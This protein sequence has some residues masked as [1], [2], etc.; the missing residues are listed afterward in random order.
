MNPSHFALDAGCALQVSAQHW[1]TA[2]SGQAEL[3]LSAVAS[4]RGAVLRLDI[5]YHGGSGF[6][7]ARKPLRARLPASWTV[8]FRLRG[9]TAAQDLEV[10]L[11]D[12][13]GRNVWRHVIRPLAASARWRR[14]EIPS[15]RIEFA[16]GPS[17]DGA[18]VELG[19]IEFAL[20]ATGGD[21][22]R[23]WLEIGD[24]RL[25]A[26]DTGGPVLA[27]ASS[28]RPGRE[29]AQA[30]TH[31]GWKPQVHD[32]SPWL[33]LD[34]QR[35][36]DF[37]GVVIE[38]EEA[39]PSTGFRIRTS[40]TGRRW[41]TRYATDRAGG[42]RSYVALPDA[43][44]RY[45]RLE[46][47][48]A[49]VGARVRLQNFTF[50]R[51]PEAY[52]QHVAAAEPRGALP[53]WLLREQCLWTPVGTPHSGAQV[54][55]D[56]DGRFEFAPG[57]ALIEPLLSVNGRLHTWADV[58]AHP[59]LQDG[60]MPQPS[61]RWETSAWTL[62]IAAE[63]TASGTLRLRYRLTNRGNRRL[64]A[65]LFLLIRPFQITP[66]WQQH[67]ELGGLRPIHRLAWDGDTLHIDG[68]GVVRP[69]SRTARA[70]AWRA[71]DGTP[72]SAVQLDSRLRGNDEAWQADDP[73]G[74][75]TGALAFEMK[76]DAGAHDE[77]LLSAASA[78]EQLADA[79]EPAFD[80][81]CVV[82]TSMLAAGG[83]AMDAMRAAWTATAHIL[84][85]RDGAALQPGPRRYR[86]SWIRDGAV[87]AA[88]LLRMKQTDAV[89][90][91]I[92]WYAPHV[93]ADGFV[94][95]CVDSRGA[96]PLVEHDSHGQWLALIADHQ[97]FAPD[98]ALLDRLW[99]S[100]E[101]TVNRIGGLLDDS[102]LLPVSVSHEGY[103]AQP[104]HA[105]WD[106]AWAVRGLR[107]MAA[108][109]RLHHRSELAQRCDDLQRRIADAL[110]ASIAAT[111]ARQSLD[112]IP[113]SV[114]WAD[115]DPTATAQ[116]ITLL[117]LP[118]QLDRTAVERTYTRYLDDWRSKR[119]NETDWV[120][121]SP[122]EIRIVG[123]LLRLGWRDAALDLLRFLLADR[124]PPAWNQWPEIAW[125]DPRTPGHL[126]DLPHTW[127]A[128]EYVLALRSLFAYESGTQDALIL[129][130]GLDAD[131]LAGE[132]VRVHDLPTTRGTLHYT[133]RRLDSATTRFELQPGVAGRIVLRPPLTG[134]IV[135]VE[136]DDETTV[137][138]DGTSVTIDRVTTPL[139]LHIR[140]SR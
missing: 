115:F 15:R 36:R 48:D 120:N 14:Y 69:L 23:G 134:T 98:P 12:A 7:V 44:F 121:Y 61:V 77:V 138:H 104:V 37:G 68:R 42:P 34:T 119:R 131:W 110:F 57:S 41:T 90:A 6:V 16:W 135:T 71:A 106:D 125:R 66:P 56:Q 21:G 76:A 111:R 82:P 63:A 127:I 11:V 129:A 32:A 122:Y 113:G 126:G 137:I 95:C 128:A 101:R 96:D 105:Y 31:V 55:I 81:A 79:A 62:R 17:H 39:A 72:P 67:G 24:L 102:G 73:E 103:L 10:K 47:R 74:Y 116:L 75:A 109:A 25:I 78:P 33:Q 54:L 5:D 140:T 108:L 29:A 19:A 88:A 51:S 133:L 58:D 87:M 99:P 83:D 35:V 38:W 1:E 132:G 136:V 4:R 40:N 118:P 18:L 65:R 43:K 107:D 22:G 9:E 64:A 3:R 13:S 60:W 92:R 86:R 70:G 130:A 85:T 49:D 52:W 123:A 46:L 97:R 28:A 112:Y 8:H 100:I 30:L 45:L 27:D 20:V 50:S 114:E 89:G 94:P 59:A 2:V 84:A 124:R 93:R 80:W 91:F 117:D 139:C 53:R 26:D